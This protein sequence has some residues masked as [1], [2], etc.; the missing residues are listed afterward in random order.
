MYIATKEEVVE[1]PDGCI[2]TCHC[3]CTC[4]LDT[5]SMVAV[6]N[7]VAVSGGLVGALIT[8]G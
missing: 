5:A 6:M 7:D 3:H 8:R 2:C 4:S 1:G